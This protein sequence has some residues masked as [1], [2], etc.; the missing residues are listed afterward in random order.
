MSFGFK[1]FLALLTI[2]RFVIVDSGIAEMLLQQ[3]IPSEPLV[4]QVACKRL[5]GTFTLGFA[6]DFKL[7]IIIIHGENMNFLSWPT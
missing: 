6:N 4:T 7:L 2:E 1:R 5:R 3:E